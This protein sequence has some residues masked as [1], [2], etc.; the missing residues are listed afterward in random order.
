[1]DEKRDIAGR[2]LRNMFSRLLSE[3]D[4]KDLEYSESGFDPEPLLD[5]LYGAPVSYEIPNATVLIYFHDLLSPTTSQ[6]Q[7][8]VGR[9]FVRGLLRPLLVND[10][11]MG[12]PVEITD[13]VYLCLYVEWCIQVLEM[14]MDD[15]LSETAAC[16]DESLDKLNRWYRGG[17]GAAYQERTSASDIIEITQQIFELLEGKDIKKLAMKALDD[18]IE[19]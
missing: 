18:T 9:E 4:L 13:R 2:L 8:Q 10:N 15:A 3:S 17:K 11:P 14:G 19:N 16:F 6:S 1:M 7:W 5:V 12:R